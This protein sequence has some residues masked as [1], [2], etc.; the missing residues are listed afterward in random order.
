[1]KIGRTAAFAMGGGILLLQV[2]QSN[3][4][5]KIDW[6]RIRKNAIKTSQV[7]EHNIVNKKPTWVDQVCYFMYLCG[8]YVDISSDF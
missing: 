6:D 2:A 4:Y 3:G 7:V 5:N 8:I 1:M